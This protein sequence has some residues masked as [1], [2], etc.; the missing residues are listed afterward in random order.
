MVCSADAVVILMP[1]YVIDVR[2]CL[3]ACVC[4]S[5]SSNDQKQTLWRIDKHPDKQNK[6]FECLYAGDIAKYQRGSPCK[7]SLPALP[8]AFYLSLCLPSCFFH[9]C[10]ITHF[11]VR[12]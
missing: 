8:N 7:P 2:W 11:P 6:Q 5:G 1:W 9:D 12:H 10:A 4:Y 3:C